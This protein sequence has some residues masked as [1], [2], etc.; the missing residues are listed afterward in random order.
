MSI[1]NQTASQYLK[2]TTGRKRD[3]EIKSRGKKGM[4]W[5]DLTD[6]VTTCNDLTWSLFCVF[7]CL[8]M[9]VMYSVCMLLPS[10]P[11]PPD[12]SNGK[13]SHCVPAQPTVAYLCGFISVLPGASGG[14]SLPSS[15][16]LHT[17]WREG[18]M[19]RSDRSWFLWCH[20]V[21]AKVT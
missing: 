5:F 9:R 7:E 11:T 1:S 3:E 16:L 2:M 6:G 18:R 15:D 19:D 21:L 8:C 10:A 17:G 13:I 14:P 4:Q 20:D 12:L